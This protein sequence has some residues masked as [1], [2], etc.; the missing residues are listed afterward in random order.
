MTTCFPT[1]PLFGTSPIVLKLAIILGSWGSFAAIS[2]LHLDRTPPSVNVQNTSGE[3]Q[4]EINSFSGLTLPGEVAGA[5]W[6]DWALFSWTD[7]NETPVRIPGP[8]IIFIWFAEED[9]S[10]IQ[11]LS[12]VSGDTPGLYA[13]IETLERP[14]TVAKTYDRVVVGGRKQLTTNGFHERRRNGMS[15]TAPNLCL[16]PVDTIY[17][18]I[19]AILDEGGSPGN[20]LFIRPVENWGFG[21]T[22]LKEDNE[23]S[24]LTELQGISVTSRNLEVMDCLDF[25]NDPSENGSVSSDT[26]SS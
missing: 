14:L 22:Q 26:S 25:E 19:A 1:P 13:M 12:C 2:W 5:S 21:F 16:V 3:L 17:Q 6:H 24:E 10:K 18:P 7:T 4:L 23:T 8:I 20:F 15:L 11:Q 9:I